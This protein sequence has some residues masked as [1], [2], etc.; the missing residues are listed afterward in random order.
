VARELVK[1]F[2]NVRVLECE[3]VTIDGVHFHGT[4]LWTRIDLQHQPILREIMN[5]YRH[6]GKFTPAVCSTLFDMNYR[7]L[8]RAVTIAGDEKH[9]VLT[10]HLPTFALVDPRH[11]G[12]DEMVNQGYATEI[13]D[14]ILPDVWLCGH[15][16]RRTEL[17]TESGVR[18]ILHCRGYPIETNDNHNLIR[19]FDL[20]TKT[21]NTV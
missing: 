20:P 11:G 6:I 8:K 21:K 18:C 7:W 2:P 4:T 17:T 5:D 3:S 9:V 16:H 10:H 13:V 15:S 19:V 1:P 12:V 14:D